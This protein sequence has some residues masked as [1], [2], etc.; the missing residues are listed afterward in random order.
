MDN[1]A[2]ILMGLLIA[3]TIF[4]GTIGY[5]IYKIIPKKSAP[6][7]EISVGAYVQPSAP[8]LPPDP[9]NFKY[10]FVH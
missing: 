4:Y 5:L 7:S 3:S 6:P 10:H 1:I 2:L 9:K 8:I